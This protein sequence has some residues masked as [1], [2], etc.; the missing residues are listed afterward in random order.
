MGIAEGSRTPTGLLIA[1]TPLVK[2]PSKTSGGWLYRATVEFAPIGVG[3]DEGVAKYREYKDLDSGAYLNNFTVMIEKPTS[4]FHFDAV[5]GGVARNDQYYGLEVG[6]YN[7]WRVRGSFSEI[8]HFFTHDLQV[9]LG[10]ERQRPV[11][12]CQDFAREARPTRIRPRRTCSWRS[13]PRRPPTS[14]SAG[15]RAGH[16]STSRCRRTGKPLP[17]MPT[18]VEKTFAR[19]APSLAVAAVAATSRSRNRSTTT[20][21]TYW[22][23][24]SSPTR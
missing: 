6:R 3:G 14:S 9:T 22:Q 18:S 7:T 11:S 12:P 16:A 13:R 5:G 4:A 21:R 20:R 17:A 1:P 8:P 23:D 15:R 19:L 2:E 10:R 24:F